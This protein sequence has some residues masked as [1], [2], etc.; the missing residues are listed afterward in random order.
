MKP[1]D[2]TFDIW[3]EQKLQI[4]GAPVNRHGAKTNQTHRCPDDLAPSFLPLELWP[5]DIHTSDNRRSACLG[6]GG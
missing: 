3:T 5:R 2:P 1:A 6:Q 4:A